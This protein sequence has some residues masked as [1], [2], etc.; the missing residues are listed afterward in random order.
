MIEEGITWIDYQTTRRVIP[1]IYG[2]RYSQCS[3]YPSQPGNEKFAGDISTGTN[4]MKASVIGLAGVSRRQQDVC[5]TRCP[6]K[7]WA[8]RAHNYEVSPKRRP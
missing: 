8:T 2:N 4:L 1:N 6:R 7:S 3:T 5:F